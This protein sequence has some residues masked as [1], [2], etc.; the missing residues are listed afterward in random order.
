VTFTTNLQYHGLLRSTNGL[1][2]FQDTT[3]VIDTIYDFNMELGDSILYNFVDDSGYVE[4]IEIDS[5]LINGQM[6]K[7]MRFSEPPIPTAFSNVN[8]SWVENIGS[9]HGP[10]FPSQPTFTSSEFPGGLDVTCTEINNTPY[11]DSPYYDECYYNIVLSSQQPERQD[12]TIYPNPTTGH[13]Y[14]QND[15]KNN[16]VGQFSVYDLLGKQI[17][18]GAVLSGKQLVDISNLQDGL[19]I[20]TL[21]V[22]EKI[23]TRRILKY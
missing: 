16:E 9:I 4:V 14:I 1:V 11:W 18:S 2:I 17:T 6:V 8:E 13:L 10:L 5:I 22:D 20:I 3:S 23:E 12:F 7:R 15:L 21:V 19:Y